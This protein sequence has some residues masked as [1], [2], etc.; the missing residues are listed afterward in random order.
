MMIMKRKT[1]GARNN[2]RLRQN[3]NKI[4]TLT[5]G[6]K[7]DFFLTMTYISMHLCTY[8][9]YKLLKLLFQYNCVCSP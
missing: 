2:D 7:V 5:F 4:D 1:G 8:I 6:F 3:R 9:V